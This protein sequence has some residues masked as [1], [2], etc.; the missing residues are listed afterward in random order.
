MAIVCSLINSQSLTGPNLLI[1]EST[2]VLCN[3]YASSH[4]TF[5]KYLHLNQIIGKAPK[6]YIA[7]YS[8]MCVLCTSTEHRKSVSPVVLWSAKH[9]ATT[10][11]QL[12]HTSVVKLQASQVNCRIRMAQGCSE[13][14]QPTSTNKRSIPTSAMEC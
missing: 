14:P 5:N 4:I 13:Q 7:F 9:K 3:L 2:T 8:M 10:E 11:R 6:R 12:H 1:I